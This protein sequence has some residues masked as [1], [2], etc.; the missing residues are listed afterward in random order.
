MCLKAEEIQKIWIPKKGDWFVLD[1]GEIDICIEDEKPRKLT[2]SYHEIAPGNEKIIS[3]TKRT[4]L[5]KQ[6]QL[7][8]MSLIP[9]L[10]F[11]KNTL[12]FFDWSEKTG[13]D[14]LTENKHRFTSLEQIRLAYLMEF[15]Y[16]KTW[17]KNTWYRLD[18]NF[19]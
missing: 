2:K 3:F 5:P 13:P 18:D 14:H 7:V 8:E 1:S 19:A 9:G 11:Q 17:Y 16:K 12:I 10:T 6:E 15:K 4:W